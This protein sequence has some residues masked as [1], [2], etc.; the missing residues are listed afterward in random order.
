M[1]EYGLDFPHGARRRHSL[2]SDLG[3][4]A[5]PTTIFF[6]AK[7]QETDRYVGASTL[8]QFNAGLAK[9]Q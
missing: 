8:A 2:V 7:G 6:D 3:I 1:Q 4:T 5:Y 9:A